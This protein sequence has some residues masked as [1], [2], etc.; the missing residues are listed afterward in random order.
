MA[1]EISKVGDLVELTSDYFTE[2]GPWIFKKGDIGKV[3]GFDDFLV[4]VCLVKKGITVVVNPR[5]IKMHPK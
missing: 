1:D 4:R 5:N 2:D 3:V